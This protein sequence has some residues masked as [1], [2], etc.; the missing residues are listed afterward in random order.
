MGSL[1]KDQFVSLT[2]TLLEKERTAEI[3]ETRCS[4]FYQ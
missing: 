1:T 3:E 4:L 2:R